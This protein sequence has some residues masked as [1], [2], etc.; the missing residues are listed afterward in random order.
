MYV[1]VTILCAP[2]FVAQM[3]LWLG[4]VSTAKTADHRST[5]TSNSM[6]P[7]SDMLNTNPQ[8]EPTCESIWQLYRG[9]F[10]ERSC[11][12]F[13]LFSIVVRS[14]S[15]WF[16]VVRCRLFFA[17]VLGLRV[18]AHLQCACLEV[19]R[20]SLPVLGLALGQVCQVSIRS[21]NRPWLTLIVIRIAGKSS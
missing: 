7:G 1:I 20:G 4:E 6:F 12:V 8:L 17:G 5:T 3:D 13:R 19:E 2:A 21:P 15:L 9:E 16:V 10:Q 11:L 18:R 14:G